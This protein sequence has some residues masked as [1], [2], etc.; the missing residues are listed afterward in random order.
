[1]APLAAGEAGAGG[2]PFGRPISPELLGLWCAEV[3]SGS[4]LA[5]LLLAA[6]LPEGAAGNLLRLHTAHQAGVLGLAF[7]AVWFAVGLYSR[8]FYRE[9]GRLLALTALGG[10]LALPAIWFAGR[11]LGIDFGAV[12]AGGVL[13]AAGALA[14]WVLFILAAR[15]AFSHAIRADLLLRRILVVGAGPDDAAADRL[16]A[17]SSRS[18]FRI[19][20]VL[21]AG[22]AVRLTPALLKAR[23]VWGIIITDG[24]RNLLSPG[25]IA[26]WQSGNRRRGRIFGAAEFW[27]RR[28]CRMDIDCPDALAAVRSRASRPGAV[29][30]ALARGG[31]ILLSLALLL[32]TLPLMLLAAALIRL[33]GPGPVLYRQ[34]RI[35]LHG[36]PFMLFKFRSM[37]P[38]AEARGPRWA[39][40]ADPRIT[41]VGHIIRHT[42]I[43]ELPQLVNVLRGEMSIVGPRPERPHFVEQLAG[44][45]PLYRERARVKPGLTGWAQVNYPYGA[46]I[47]DARAKLSYDLYYVRHRGPALTL[48]I[49]LLTVWVVLF[50]KG[51]R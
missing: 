51:A 32:F 35:G 12:M 17:A 48:R 7:G 13:P 31:D 28:L 46:S 8:D 9:T 19:I 11:V 21:P 22:E 25:Q 41:R 4:L 29:S 49:L 27:E 24:A 26:L 1:L 5:Y 38:D 15:L 33:D 18:R 23:R 43:D 36:R 6:G 30:A 45:L 10:C 39:I 34:R 44:A 40:P 47:E 20:S 50:Q 2:K 3:A 37:L 14:G 42:R 16:V